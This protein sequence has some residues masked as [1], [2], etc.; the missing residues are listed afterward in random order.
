MNKTDYAAEVYA[1]YGN[2][3]PYRESTQKTAGYTKEKWS[4]LEN[5]I[6]D[7]LAAFAAVMLE[8][9]L[10]ESSAAQTLVKKLQDFITENLYT[11][12]LPILKGLGTMYVSDPRFRENI[13]RHAPGNAAYVAKAIETYCET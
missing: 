4:D 11:C 8:G 2:T 5:G 9:A 12:T 13:D 1:R 6:N 3:A 10:P 7:L